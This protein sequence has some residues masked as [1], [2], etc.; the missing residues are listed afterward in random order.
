L[1][2]HCFDF[3]HQSEKRKGHQTKL[4]QNKS[5]TPQLC[6]KH[7]Q[8]KEF[9]C[10]KEKVRVCSIC[11]NND[12][13]THEIVTLKEAAFLAKQKL[14]PLNYNKIKL[15][16]KEDLNFF[17]EQIDKERKKF[18]HWM[19]ESME[20]MKTKMDEYELLEKIAKNIERE[21]NYDHLI[22]WRIFIEENSWINSIVQTI[23]KSEHQLFACGR[24]VNGTLGFGDISNR[25]HFEEIKFFHNKEIQKISCGAFF[26]FILCG[27][28]NHINSR[29]QTL[30]DWRKREGPI[31]SWTQQQSI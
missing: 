3:F 20:H 18:D 14:G 30:F 4:I 17:E 15:K 6:S 24:N 9:F 29:K 2:E 21:E 31:R 12:H 16:F 8:N 27:K 28:F 26:T 7:N 1:C 10:L 11:A 25:D 19:E 22:D 5:F 13:K 23:K